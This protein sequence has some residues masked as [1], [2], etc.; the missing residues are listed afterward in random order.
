MSCFQCSLCHQ[1]LSLHDAC[2]RCVG[3]HSFDLAKDGYV[4]LLPVQ[5]K[6][7]K[8]PGDALLMMAVRCAFLDAGHYQP[9]R[10]RVIAAVAALTPEPGLRWLDIGCGE[11]YY[12]AALV[13]QLKHHQ[14][15]AEVYGMDIAKNAVRSAA[16]RYRQVRFCVASSQRL[17]FVDASLDGIMRIYAPSNPA[18]LRRTLCP[19]GRAADGDSRPAPSLSA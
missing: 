4:N 16:K 12:I 14:P 1:P 2:Y 3:Q 9:L 6:H 19:G 7:S 15:Q 13:D 11:G 8:D 17:P 18:E 5:F 10:D